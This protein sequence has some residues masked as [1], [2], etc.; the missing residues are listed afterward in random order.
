MKPLKN[1]VLYTGDYNYPFAHH[2]GRTGSGPYT[3]EVLHDHADLLAG[4]GVDTYVVD[5][6][7][8]VPCTPAKRS[9]TS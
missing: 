2:Y 8:H 5:P 1:R 6:N 7:G 9:I 3:A 4:S